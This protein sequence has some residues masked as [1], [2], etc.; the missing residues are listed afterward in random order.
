MPPPPA[1]TIECYLHFIHNIII[2]NNISHR[3]TFLCRM[4]TFT[5]DSLSTFS[6]LLNWHFYLSKRSDC[7]FQPCSSVDLTYSLFLFGV[8][9]QF[10]CTW[11]F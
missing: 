7:F 8:I 2:I 5:F 4:S 9:Y 10:S 1:T 3:G 11:L 6:T